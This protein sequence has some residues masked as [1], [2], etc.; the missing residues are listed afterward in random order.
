MSNFERFSLTIARWL[1]H[2]YDEDNPAES[3]TNPGDVAT[4]QLDGLENWYLVHR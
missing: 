3:S 1:T 2:V 4:L